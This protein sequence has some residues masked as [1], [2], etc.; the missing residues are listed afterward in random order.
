MLFDKEQREN[1]RLRQQELDSRE[2]M[3]QAFPE[4]AI[5][6]VPSE[7]ANMATLENSHD[8][9]PDTTLAT[10]TLPVTALAAEAA[11]RARAR[12]AD[13]HQAVHAVVPSTVKSVALKMAVKDDG[14]DPPTTMLNA[15]P[16]PVQAARH[17]VSTV[18]MLRGALPPAQS[19]STLSPS[20]TQATTPTSAVCAVMAAAAKLRM[21]GTHATKTTTVI[22]RSG[23]NTIA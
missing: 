1:F 2:A 23:A 19:R 17:G 12:E 6:P 14:R 5:T 22:Q 11:Q 15:P 4:G 8:F 20:V 7:M 21:V 16:P 9:T 13:E 10:D 18:S 3:P